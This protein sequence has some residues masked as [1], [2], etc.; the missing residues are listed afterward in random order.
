M[1][2]DTFHNASKL[3]RT[4]DR[5]MDQV[6]VVSFD[7]FDTLLVRRVHDPDLVKVPV[8]RLISSLAE[9]KGVDLSWQE[10][11]ELRDEIEQGTRDENGR[12][13]PDH[14]AH[15][16]TFMAMLIER[17]FGEQSDDAMLRRITDYEILME[18]AMLVPRQDIKDWIESLFARGRKSTPYRTCTCPPVILSGC[19]STRVCSTSSKRWFPRP[20]A[21]GPRRRVQA[22]N[23]SGI[24]SA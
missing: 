24:N 23:W 4:A 13:H 20:T 15:Y 7:V 6:D 8:A 5:I 18:N 12:N 2:F 3:I 1:N 21:L 10:V 14:E 22:M 11:Q 16:P 9:E 19:W 17:I